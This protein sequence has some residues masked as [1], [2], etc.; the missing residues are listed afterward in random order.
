MSKTTHTIRQA[1]SMPEEIEKMR[2]FL[3]EVEEKLLEMDG[4]EFFA[5]FSL[6]YAKRFSPFWQRLFFGY[7]VLIE[8][9]CNTNLDYLSWKPEIQA[10][11]NAA[12]QGETE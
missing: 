1:R 3:Y 7:E 5:W 12:E 9:A 6:E 8:N 2:E 10:A 4:D 11:L